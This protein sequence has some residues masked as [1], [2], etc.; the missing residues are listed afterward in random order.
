MSTRKLRVGIIGCGNIG[1]G[2]HLPAWLTSR[3]IAEVVALADPTESTLTAAAAVAGL[4]D[5]QIHRDPLE[6]IARPDVDAIDICTPQHL[7]RDLIVEAAARGKHILCEKPLATVP[8]DAAAAVEAAAASD[9]TFAMMH[10]YLWLPEVRAAQRVID[11]REIGTVRT[12]T[13]NYLG[14]V[15]VP[16][17]AGYAPRW[18]HDAAHAGGGVLVDILHGIYVAESLLGHHLERVSAYAD[19]IDPDSNVEDLALCRFETAANAALVNI[20]WGLGPGGME[21]TGTEG[22]ISV[23][24]ENGGTAPWSQFERVLVT[25][26]AGTRTEHDAA[27]DG[28]ADGY[29]AL[30]D[31]FQHVFRD[32][33]HAVLNGSTPRATGADG[34][35]ILEAT[36]G[37]LESAA[38]GRMVPIPLDRDD[39]VFQQGVLGVNDLDLP[40]W[41]PVHRRSLYRQTAATVEEN[42]S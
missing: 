22:R 42:R 16:G 5:D 24:Y 20:A 13:I 27:V 11:A 14:I 3:E 30:G 25:T 18:R 23:V 6:L 31:A 26:A 12:V 38:T 40:D 4:G 39:P 36:V 37:A 34:L 10:N 8:A 21:I 35:R 28:G 29:A 17:N 19:N 7:R 9:A 2:A 1:G 33:A 15:D 32:F 41:S